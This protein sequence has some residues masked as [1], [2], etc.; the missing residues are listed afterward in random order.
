MLDSIPF[1][2]PTAE[3]ADGTW[4]RFVPSPVPW[5]ACRGHRGREGPVLFRV[6]DE[7]IHR[8]LGGFDFDELFTHRNTFVVKELRQSFYMKKGRPAQ[9][10]GGSRVIEEVEDAVETRLT[11]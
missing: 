5:L 6:G 10:S 8:S 11:A 9:T 3:S 2:Q 7:R 1:T 4:R